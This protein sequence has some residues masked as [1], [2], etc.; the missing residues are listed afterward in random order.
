MH[1]QPSGGGDL[2][3]LQGVIDH[4]EA[5]LQKA[6]AAGAP[7]QVLDLIERDLE[8]LKRAQST[9]SVFLR[10]KTDD[11]G[12]ILGFNLPEAGNKGDD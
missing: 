3:T 4:T 8:V 10:A 11:G 12:T 1:D 7:Q 2:P 9:G 5:E 6:R